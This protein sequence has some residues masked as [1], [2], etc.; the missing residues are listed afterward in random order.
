MARRRGRIVFWGTVFVA[1]G[2]ERH[3]PPLAH[4]AFC[5]FL[6]LFHSH[7]PPEAVPGHAMITYGPTSVNGLL[8]LVNL[9]HA[10]LLRDENRARFWEVGRQVASALQARAWTGTEYR[11]SDT[12]PGLFLYPNV[13]MILL[14]GRLYQLTG[15][16]A[17]RDQAL[18][19]Y[20]AIQPLRVTSATGWVGPGRYRSP[21]SAEHMG[22]RTDDYTTLSSQNY[23]ILALYVLYQITKATRVPEAT[24]LGASLRTLL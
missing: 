22:A 13:T 2:G 20:R 21:Y 11:F 19:T 14:H 17:F 6:E 16:P 12:R 7:V 18:A 10:L 23:M 1:C 15:D 5:K 4:Q 3:P 8:A 24:S 9:Q